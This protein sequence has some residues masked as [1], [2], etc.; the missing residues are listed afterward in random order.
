MHNLQIPQNTRFLRTRFYIQECPS[1]VGVLQH[2]F[3][4]SKGISCTSLRRGILDKICHQ[5][6]PYD[7]L[8]AR[9]LRNDYQRA[10]YKDNFSRVLFF[11]FTSSGFCKQPVLFE[12]LAPT[13]P[14]LRRS[15][16]QREYRKRTSLPSKSSTIKGLF[17]TPDPDQ[18]KKGMLSDQPGL[19]CV[20]S[21]AL[22]CCC[23]RS[24]SK[25]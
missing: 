1:S 9:K 21:M 12:V 20:T 15:H 10:T 11:W 22:L 17:Y 14:F 24:C 6:F 19:S 18:C 2:Y 25:V 23:G 13:C 3:K 5:F 4:S 16:M 7:L 8:N